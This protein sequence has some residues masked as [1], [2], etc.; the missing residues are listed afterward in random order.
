M[1]EQIFGLIAF[2]LC[3]ARMQMKTKEGF[4]AMN[5][6]INFLFGI[7]Y[8]ILSAGIGV[9]ISFA[10]ATRSSLLL[11]PLGQKFRNTVVT[12]TTAGIVISAAFTLTHIPEVLFLL[13]PFLYAYAEYQHSQFVLRCMV[14]I[15]AII[16]MVYSV[17]VFNLGGIL[18]GTANIS[19]NLVGFWRFHKNDLKTAFSNPRLFF[20][21]P[22][23]INR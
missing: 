9:I 10:A 12:I 3:I 11:T 20:Y 16:M 4:M 14:L 23:E 13:P 7:Q 6:L 18:S 8:L 1:F 17:V 15:A 21:A 2:L 22:P 5:A 19:S